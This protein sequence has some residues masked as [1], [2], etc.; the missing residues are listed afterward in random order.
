MAQGGSAP[1]LLAKAC[2]LGGGVVFGV[3]G[4]KWSPDGGKILILTLD[5]RLHVIDA[6]SASQRWSGRPT[7]RSRG[8]PCHETPLDTPTTS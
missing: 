8:G 4:P 6:G 1:R 2:C 7:E 3:E 5:G